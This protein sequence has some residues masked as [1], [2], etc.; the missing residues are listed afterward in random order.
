MKKTARQRRNLP[1]HYHDYDKDPFCITE[2]RDAKRPGL[3]WIVRSRLFGKWKRTFFKT[4]R[5]ALKY[6]YDSFSIAFNTANVESLIDLS[7][8]K[9][10]MKPAD[11]F[12]ASFG[13][14]AQR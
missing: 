13:A 11:F 8:S 5:E 4:E 1:E 10:Q 7:G 12:D 2:Y 9:V 6:Y 14:K 3:K